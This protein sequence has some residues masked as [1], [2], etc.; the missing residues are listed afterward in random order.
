MYHE[1]KFHFTVDDKK[2][3]DDGEVTFTFY[4]INA[5]FARMKHS[6]ASATCK[7][8]LLFRDVP[9]V[10]AQRDAVNVYHIL[11]V[12]LVPIFT[13]LRDFGLDGAKFQIIFLNHWGNVADDSD[14]GKKWLGF[15]ERMS[16]GVPPITPE[17]LPATICATTAI[18]GPTPHGPGL[19]M[20]NTDKYDY[21]SEHYR[22]KETMKHYVSWI[23]QGFG[24]VQGDGYADPPKLLI[25]ER[26][27]EDRRQMHGVEHIE[28][29]ANDRGWIVQKLLPSVT[30]VEDQLKAVL[31]ANLLITV[32]GAAFALAA[33][34]PRKAVAVELMPYGFVPGDDFYAGYANWLDM[35]GVTHIVWHEQ[36]V[37]SHVHQDN[38]GAKD[39]IRCGKQADLFL[40]YLDVVHICDAAHRVY[41]TPLRQR[42]AGEVL[43]L[44]RPAVQR[45]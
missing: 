15:F 27:P 6:Q 34:L 3:S 33:F 31:S 32:H 23:L 5:T 7:G 41:I 26:G 10:I 4:G 17:T 1:N 14:V 44:N 42:F 19:H 18:V 21:V 29:V 35:A 30:S 16:G 45:C 11:N 43:Y 13:A 39:I 25:L 37:D 24:L 28:K 12:Q 36:G 2:A 9:L 22:S 20:S 40:G 8:A 38:D